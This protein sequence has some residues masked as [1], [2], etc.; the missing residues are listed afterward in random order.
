MTYRAV[1]GMRG[2]NGEQHSR[3]YAAAYAISGR[4]S[5]LLKAGFLA[6]AMGYELPQDMER[7]LHTRA[8]AGRQEPLGPQARRAVRRDLTPQQ[9]TTPGSGANR[10]P[11]AAPPAAPPA[12][13]IIIAPTIQGAH[14]E[15]NAAPEPSPAPPPR[16]QSTVKTPKPAGTTR[17]KRTSKPK[18]PPEAS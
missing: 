5:P 3:L 4:K 11:A 13:P 15:V 6:N 9:R 10:A 8:A 14:I 2:E 12:P 17:T 7:A 1:R 16:R 18:Q